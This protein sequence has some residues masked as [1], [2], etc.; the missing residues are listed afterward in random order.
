MIDGIKPLRDQVG[1]AWMYNPHSDAVKIPV[2]P[3]TINSALVISVLNLS[4][5]DLDNQLL[6]LLK[7][8]TDYHLLKNVP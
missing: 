1:P 5:K 2:M 8:Q 7:L 6:G 3:N 4:K